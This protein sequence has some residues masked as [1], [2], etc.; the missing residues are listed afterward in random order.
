MWEALG[1]LINIIFFIFIIYFLCQNKHI[2]VVQLLL[3]GLFILPPFT[4]SGNKIS[5]SY[6]AL[7][8]LLCYIG[9]TGS[10][11]KTYYPKKIFLIFFMFL[12]PIFV[13]LVSTFFS[14]IIKGNTMILWIPLIGILKN[15]FL[16]L[17]I[18][19][20]LYKRLKQNKNTD[21]ECLIG[22]LIPVFQIVMSA[23]L[24]F[25]FI[26]LLQPNLG[27]KIVQ[28]YSSETKST[29]PVLAISDGVFPRL[30]GLN[31]SPVLL[32]AKSLLC[33]T[34]SL[35][36]IIQKT[37][38]ETK[39]KL[40]VLLMLSLINGIFSFS[41]TFILG[42]L[43]SLF[44]YILFFLINV[45]KMRLI[46]I[47]EIILIVLI[48]ICFIVIIINSKNLS[49]ITKLPF[50]YYF[51]FIVTN[52]LEALK[53]RY[54]YESVPV[55]TQ[56][57]YDIIKANPILGVGYTSPLGE[58]IGDSEYLVAMH[59]GGIVSLLLKLSLIVFLLFVSLKRQDKFF[60]GI[61]VA[62]LITGFA[63]P[64]LYSDIFI[65]LIGAYISYAIFYE[66]L[67]RY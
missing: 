4:F 48:G 54:I 24:I 27:F 62:C 3:I 8:I 57:T 60:L 45:I 31:Y 65:V 9:I 21:R 47:R 58:F 59:H 11:L 66:E 39:R 17:S 35:F 29:L 40:L 13:E 5:F 30:Y 51:G 55:D 28:W 32:G 7:I 14:V 23:N 16:F 1:S 67:S 34:S 50:S 2:L 12:L 37:N 64:A 19:L 46:Q 26:Q 18:A 52:P 61:I 41:K 25:I 56:L 33:F 20:I 6:F 10:Y 49:T 38:P 36:G 63:L 44:I 43:L 53:T 42:S 15:I 22:L